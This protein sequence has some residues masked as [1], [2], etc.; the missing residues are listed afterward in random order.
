[1]QIAGRTFRTGQCTFHDGEIV[2]GVK[3]ACLQTPPIIAGMRNLMRVSEN[4]DNACI[5]RKKK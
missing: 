5:V 1:M 3:G 2:R 4:L